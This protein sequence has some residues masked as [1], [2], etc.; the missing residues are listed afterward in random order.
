MLL[1]RFVLRESTA[2][3]TSHNRIKLHCLAEAIE[4]YRRIVV[5]VLFL[6][7]FFFCLMNLRIRDFTFVE[8][9]LKKWNSNRCINDY[10][11]PLN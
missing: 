11:D 10:I 5:C 8:S 3:K 4:T 7:S 6:F 1:S 9:D 2:Q